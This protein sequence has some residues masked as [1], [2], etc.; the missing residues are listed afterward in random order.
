MNNLM[1]WAMVRGWCCDICG[2]RPI[3]MFE[4]WII[5]GLHWGITHGVCY[6]D[7]CNA[8]YTMLP[9]DGVPKSIIKPEFKEAT[10]AIWKEKHILVTDMTDDDFKEV[11]LANKGEG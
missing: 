6:C 2:N 9:Y 11:E 7:K 8:P 3:F 4:N 1:N 10:I 5:L